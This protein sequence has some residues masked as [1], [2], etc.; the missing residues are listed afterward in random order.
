MLFT[1]PFVIGETSHVSE[2]GR[3]G[4][5]SLLYKLE[6]RE[7]L[8]KLNPYFPETRCWLSPR[9]THT[10]PAP[11]LGRINGAYMVYARSACDM[12]KVLMIS[13]AYV[14]AGMFL[15]TPRAVGDIYSGMSY[16]QNNLIL[17]GSGSMSRVVSM[18][19]SRL[20]KLVDMIRLW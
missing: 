11:I 8:R 2:A 16:P 13:N 14:I 6:T 1:Q 3:I 5:R 4:F 19:F 12:V 17:R 10:Q 18:G 15:V 9:L 20:S 7:S